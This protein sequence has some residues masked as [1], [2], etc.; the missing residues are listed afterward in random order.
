MC[1]V[2]CCCCKPMPS[3]GLG[4]GGKKHAKNQEA[5]V[6]AAAV[7]C[8]GAPAAA[9]EIEK[10]DKH[11]SIRRVQDQG[12]RGGQLFFSP[13]RSCHSSAR[14]WAQ[15]PLNGRLRKTLLPKTPEFPLWE[16]SRGSA[17]AAVFFVFP[18]TRLRTEFYV[19]PDRPTDTA[20]S[21]GRVDQ[22]TDH[23]RACARARSCAPARRAPSRRPA[24]PPSAAGVGVGE[25]K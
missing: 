24:V 14:V 13:H 2:W 15:P 12:Q 25:E 23:A 21:C 10:D 20:R 6:V 18:K 1:V 22:Q 8:C 17:G 16:R 4:A 9:R 5:A 3:E 19:F 11:A 7:H